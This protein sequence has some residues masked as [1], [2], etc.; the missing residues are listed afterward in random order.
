MEEYTKFC[1]RISIFFLILAIIFYV[2]IC[3]L[4]DENEELRSLNTKPSCVCNCQEYVHC[5]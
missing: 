5:D 2:I 4:I 1:E 3:I